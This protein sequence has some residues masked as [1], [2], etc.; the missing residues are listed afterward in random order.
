MMSPEDLNWQMSRLFVLAIALLGFVMKLVALL[1]PDVRRKT[2]WRFVLSPLPA[3][4]SMRRAEPLA[5]ASRLILPTLW[6][7]AVLVAGYWSYWKLVRAFGIHGILLSYLAAPFL[8]F[9]G[10]LLAPLVTPLWL[11]SGL[12]LPAVHNHPP[13]MRSVGDFWGCRWNLWFSDW[14]RYAV[15]GRCRRRPVSALILVFALSGLMHEWVINVPLW[16]VTGRFLF[17]TMMLYFLLQAVG[18]LVERRFLKGRA[19]WRIALAWLVVFVPAPL[20]INEGL[21]RALHLWPG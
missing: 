19:R 4:T 7:A 18:I 6:L 13:L 14:F 1:L 3:P 21:L 16:F 2:D 8:L 15:F 9:M 10:Y 17:G 12:V 5:G 20:I 11:P